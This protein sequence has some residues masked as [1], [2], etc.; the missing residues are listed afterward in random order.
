MAPSESARKLRWGILSTGGMACGKMIPAIGRSEL[1]VV[2]GVVSRDPARAA[3]VAEQ[4][5]AQAFDDLD[6]LLAS[7]DID[8]IYNP[9][10]TAQHVPVTR[11]A[12]AAGKHVLCEKPIAMTLSEAL[13]LRDLPAGG[14]HVME[15][16]MVRH[17]PQWHHLRGMLQ[18]GQVFG[19]LQS[20]QA[21][22]C[23]GLTDPNAGTNRADEGGGA[24][25][26]V[27]GYPIVVARYLLGSEPFRVL[28]TD[29][30]DA[31]LGTD[32]ICTGIVDFGGGLHL[33]FNLGTAG[34]RHQ[35][36]RLIGTHG[37]VHVQIPF[38]TPETADVAL[39]TDRSDDLSGAG[40]DTI[41]IPAIDQFAA[42][43]DHFAAA[44]LNGTAPDYGVEDAIANMRVIE[45]ARLSAAQNRWVHLDELPA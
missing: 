9:L 14:P 31:Q 8:A 35:S 1:G 42:E 24:L 27:G 45:A 19:A 16:Y 17:H 3:V 33:S 30:R 41:T 40:R 23:Y 15:A 12:V 10:P 21:S 13:S 44:I 28:M 2:A 6:A 5:G 25:L 18:D 39:Y 7:P 37:H 4:C 11:R 26:Y 43:A 36:V 22:F 29:A 32:T 34:G 20:I 38:N